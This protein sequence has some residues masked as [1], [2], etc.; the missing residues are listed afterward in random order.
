M[1]IHGLLT[2]RFVVFVKKGFGALDDVTRIGL[3]V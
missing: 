1:S 2:W 3:D